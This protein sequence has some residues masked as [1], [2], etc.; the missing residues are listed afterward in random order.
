MEDEVID[1][2]PSHQNTIDGHHILDRGG[3]NT[4]LRS[5]VVRLASTRA[6][7]ELFESKPSDNESCNQES[8]Q[9]AHAE[10]VGKSEPKLPQ[11]KS[12]VNTVQPQVV[13]VNVEIITP[14]AEGAS[15][16]PSLQPRIDAS[17][18]CQLT[19]PSRPPED[20]RD[21]ETSTREL[22][23]SPTR[24]ET[25]DSGWSD[26]ERVRESYS[27][28][29]ESSSRPSSMQDSYQGDTLPPDNTLQNTQNSRRNGWKPITHR[30]W[31]L[32]PFLL[33]ELGVLGAIIAMQVVSKRDS[34]LSTITTEDSNLKV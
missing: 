25:S 6:V 17:G 22:I 31:F 28:N 18:S 13:E 10:A 27:R 16:T 7:E 34:G 19:P 33:F 14:N 20:I 11:G 12:E 32:L 5:S 8:Y 23:N 24:T 26:G 29:S 15:Y 1:S 21:I 30:V 9:Q 3:D 4:G 2:P